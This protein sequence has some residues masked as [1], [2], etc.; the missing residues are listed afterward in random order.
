MLADGR[1]GQQQTFSGCAEAASLD[2][3][4]KNF[5]LVEI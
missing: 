4:R 5:Q 1:L 3:D 2:D